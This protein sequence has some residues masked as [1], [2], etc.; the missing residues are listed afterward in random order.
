MF[1]GK[2]GGRRKEGRPKLRWLDCIEYDLKSVGV[3]RWRK[4]A[5]GRFVLGYH[6][7]GGTG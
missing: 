6:S 4:K 5:E 7:E 3:K 2:P 1:R